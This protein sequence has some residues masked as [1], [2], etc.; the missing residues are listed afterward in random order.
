MSESERMRDS[1]TEEKERIS[2]I[3]LQHVYSLSREDDGV[4][5]VGRIASALA[6]PVAEVVQIVAHLTYTGFLSWEG[7]GRPV[8]I[9]EKGIEYIEHL[10]HRRHSLRLPRE[11]AATVP[12][13][14]FTRDW[15]WH[16][17]G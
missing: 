3:L 6:L 17:T 11:D 9:T 14:A 5:V 4:L 15:E 7:T 16:P 12:G 1:E 8:G 2:F 13:T 10:A